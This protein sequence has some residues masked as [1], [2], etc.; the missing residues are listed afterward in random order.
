M[1]LC[2]LGEII[3]AVNEFIIV[4]LCKI[5]LPIFKSDK[6]SFTLEQFVILRDILRQDHEGKEDCPFN[7]TVVGPGHGTVHGFVWTC[8]QSLVSFNVMR[9]TCRTMTQ[10]FLIE[11]TKALVQRFTSILYLMENCNK[12]GVQLFPVTRV[13]RRVT[14]ITWVRLSMI[15]CIACFVVIIHSRLVKRI[16]LVATDVENELISVKKIINFIA[17]NEDL[18]PVRSH[19]SA[20]RVICQSFLELIE[21]GDKDSLAV[22]S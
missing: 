17:N 22:G 3:M 21:T 15:C 9:D 6:F 20:N 11:Y 1:L 2:N 7:I 12:L 5:F 4:K 18:F 13:G 19:F 14:C 10:S 8:N 16:R